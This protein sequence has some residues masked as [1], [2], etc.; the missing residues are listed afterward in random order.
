LDT[1][2]LCALPDFSDTGFQGEIMRTNPS[3]AVAFLASAMSLGIFSSNAFGDT[4][5]LGAALP[6]G[7]VPAG[8][9]GFDWGSA[10]NDSG[11][12]AY[13][14][15]TAPAASVEQFTSATPFTLTGINFANWMSEYTAEGQVSNYTTVISGYLNNTLVESVT[16]KYGWSYGAFSGLDVAGVNKITLSTTAFITD[17][18]CCDSNGNPQTV[19]EYNGPDTTF[20]SSIT[21]DRLAQAP[22]LDSNSAASALTL[23]IGILL[24]LRRRQ[25]ALS[26]TYTTNAPRA[27]L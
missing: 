10:I 16:E 18:S 15:I 17:T 26:G 27:A 14:Y 24:V 5:P 13:Y 1:F 11:D 2:L 20:V 8:Y 6:S 23:F 3:C 7:P 21:V 22:E 12:I 9:G 19:I 25:R 4:V